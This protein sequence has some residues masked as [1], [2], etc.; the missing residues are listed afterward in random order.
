MCIRTLGAWYLMTGAVFTAL[1]IV[2]VVLASSA[3]S[4]ASSAQSLAPSAQSLA[5]SAQS[6]VAW[7]ADLESGNL[8]QWGW[9]HEKESG[10]VSTVESPVRQGRYA[11]RFEVRSG[12]NNVAGS[13]T[14]ERAEVLDPG[15]TN[16]DASEGREAY[17]AWSTYFPS[18]F[19]APMGQWNVF[20]Q[21]HH[22]GSTGQSNIHFDVRDLSTIG[23]RVMGGNANSPTRRDFTLASLTRGKWYD[24][25]FHVRWA[26]DNTGFVEVWVDGNKV[27]DKTN[28]P[29]LYSGMFAYLKQGY[30][31]SAHSGTTVIYHDGTRRGTSY[32]DVAA[33]FSPSV[34]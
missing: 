9:V 6:T 10:R 30:Y 8:S 21:F 15:G 26:S 12:D 20:T 22:S 7:R 18:D 28:T 24:F 17:W 25:V 16:S 2:A 31:R 3:Q 32:E 14:G 5:S 33:E 11:A 4:L 29:T 1:Y 27:V 13:G 34:P 23:L 19:D